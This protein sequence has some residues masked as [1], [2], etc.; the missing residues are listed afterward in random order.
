MDWKERVEKIFDVHEYSE[1]KKVKL[2]MVEFSRHASTWWRKT[3]RTREEQCKKLFYSW[4]TLNNTWIW[5][6]LTRSYNPLLTIHGNKPH[7]TIWNKHHQLINE[8]NKLPGC[9]ESTFANSLI[10]NESN[11]IKDITQFSR[12]WKNGKILISLWVV[13]FLLSSPLLL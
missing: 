8:Q 13:F 2:A 9:R 10:H 11:R 1:R 6:S 5:S 7:H 4:S 3:C 12:I